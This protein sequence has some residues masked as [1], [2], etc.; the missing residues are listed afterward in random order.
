[1]LCPLGRKLAANEE[2]HNETTEGVG[3]WLDNGN[4]LKGARPFHNLRTETPHSE[5]THRKKQEIQPIQVDHLD[6]SIVV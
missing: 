6:V 5:L 2:L 3:R 4:N 1:M